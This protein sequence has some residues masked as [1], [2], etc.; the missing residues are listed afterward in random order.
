MR[1]IGK[2]ISFITTFDTI[3]GDSYDKYNQFARITRRQCEK[4]KNF[5]YRPL[6]YKNILHVQSEILKFPK[7][8]YNFYSN[9]LYTSHFD[10]I[11]TTNVNTRTQLVA[12]FAENPKCV[13]KPTAEIQ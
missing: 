4:E 11:S 2:S 10:K 6:E 12:S 7:E 9:Q 3:T 13:K 1:Y 5:K 8:R